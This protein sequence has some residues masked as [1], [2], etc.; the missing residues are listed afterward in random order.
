[1]ILFI[2]YNTLKIKERYEVT[3]D[4]SLFSIM[5][6]NKIKHTPNGF[7]FDTSILKSDD[8]WFNLF[9]ETKEYQRYLRKIKLEN[10]YIK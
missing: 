6:N 8:K 3:G 1:M 10:L 9:R 5:F 2:D 7:Y 4:K